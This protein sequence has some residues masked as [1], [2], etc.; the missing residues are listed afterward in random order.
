VYTYCIIMHYTWLEFIKRLDNAHG[1]R[2][3]IGSDIDKDCV[4]CVS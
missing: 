2:H 1:N 3:L 4:H